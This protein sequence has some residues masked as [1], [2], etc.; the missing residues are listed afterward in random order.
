MRR[1]T[2]SSSVSTLF[3]RTQCAEQVRRRARVAELARVRAG[4]GEAEHGGRVAQQLRDLGLVGVRDRHAE[5]RLEIGREREVEHQVD[6]VD[7]A[8][9]RDRRDAALGERGLG[10]DTR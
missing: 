7:A 3:S 4:V 5:A 1:R 10:R 2:P 6:R 9:R 8:L